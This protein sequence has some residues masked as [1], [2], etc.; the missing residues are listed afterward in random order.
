[1][2]GTVTAYY[3]LNY[4]DQ[5]MLPG[6]GQACLDAYNA[7]VSCP[8]AIGSLYADLY[9]SFNTTV[10]DTLCSAVCFDSLVA[11]RRNVSDACGSSQTYYSQNDGSTWPATYKVD[12]AIYNYNLTC[13]TRIDDGEY[14]NMWFQTAENVTAVPECDECYLQTVYMQM[15]SPLDQDPAE[16]L[17]IYA[18]MSS[19][20]SYTGP[21]AS[22][23]VTGLAIASPTA[24]LTCTL[25]YSVQASDTYL[26]VS[27]SQNVATH[28]L[29]TANG[30]NYNLS[31]FPST[32]SL[33]CIRNQCTVYL[34]Q[35]NDTCDSIATAGG[36]SLAQLHAWN[37][38]INGLCNN[39]ND[40]V[41]QTICLSNPLGDY[42]VSN[43]S[44]AATATYITTIAPQPTDL[45]SGTNTDC[46]EYYE[47]AAGEDCGTIELKFAITLDDFLFL[48]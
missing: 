38:Q 44:G 27:E 16:I 26:S 25:Q 12:D 37:A 22:Q 24:T 20:C 42:T 48:K 39:L 32:G 9:P 1:M 6:A 17:S 47:V 45:A 29:V 7:N 2:A 21:A 11:H 33:L 18:S 5:T 30:L 10:L 31:D 46:G 19:S 36:I 35:A 41:G 40:T 28:D 43:T 34:V 14:C 3:P 8:Q 13:L 23:T 15:Q 4:A